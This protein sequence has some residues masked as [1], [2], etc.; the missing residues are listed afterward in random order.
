MLL[1]LHL[2]L[3]LYVWQSWF[4]A[5]RKTETILKLQKAWERVSEADGV[6]ICL[7][8]P[9]SSSPEFLQ[10][11]VFYDCI[12]WLPFVPI[13]AIQGGKNTFTTHPKCISQHMWQSEVNAHSSIQRDAFQLYSTWNFFSFIV[14]KFKS[15]LKFK[16][17]CHRL[18]PATENWRQLGQDLE[19]RWIFFCRTFGLSRCIAK[20]S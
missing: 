7:L 12:L 5:W 10:H 20:C 11:H 14:Q 6:L 9:I 8:S 19:Y 3:G 1:G 13:L 4:Y 18:N 2:A 16:S 15:S 17:C